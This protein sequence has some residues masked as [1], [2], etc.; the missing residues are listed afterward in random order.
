MGARPLRRVIQEKVENPLSEALLAQKFR[1][2]DTILF[3]LDKNGELKMIKKRSRPS[4][5]K[6][7]E[8]AQL[9]SAY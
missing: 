6:G 9:P 2:G 3:T 5:S 8:P 4:Q 1:E 7:V